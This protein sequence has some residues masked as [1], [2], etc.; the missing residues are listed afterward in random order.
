[1]FQNFLQLENVCFC[2]S[3]PACYVMGIMIF[4]HR[5]NLA[6]VSRGQEGSRYPSGFSITRVQASSA[7]GCLL[8]RRERGPER[9]SGQ[10][11]AR[12]SRGTSNASAFRL[13]PMLDGF[14]VI[15]SSSFSRSSCL[16]GHHVR[17]F[18]R[19]VF[20]RRSVHGKRCSRRPCR[21]SDG[22]C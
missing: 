16:V 13:R 15:V 8:R 11:R 3:S 6:G 12:G 4:F 9:C 5:W 22:G 10:V 14:D 7:P 20:F 17:R 19:R 1:M 18:D 21:R 2:Y